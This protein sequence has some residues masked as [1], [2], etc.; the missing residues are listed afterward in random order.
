[1]N[2][3]LFQVVLFSFICVLSACS[4]PMNNISQQT[5]IDKMNSDNKLILLDVRSADEFSQGH[6]EGAVNIPHS[7]LA[8]RIKELG[9]NKQINIVTYCR[10]GRRANV[11]EDYLIKNGFNNIEHLEGDYPKWLKNGMPTR[12]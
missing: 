9:V 10:S 8:E 1:M 12:K 7:E 2:R 4:T 6:I 3:Q 11:A 5:L